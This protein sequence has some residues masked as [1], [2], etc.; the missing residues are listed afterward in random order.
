MS[1]EEQAHLNVATSPRPQFPRRPSA[2]LM[3]SDLSTGGTE[4]QY[5]LMAKALRRGLFDLHT[6]C[7]RRRGA[8]LKEIEPIAEFDVGGSFLTYQAHCARRAL[9]KHLRKHEIAVAHSFDFYANLMLI[10]VARWTRVPVVI[11]SQRQLGDLLSPMQKFT[12][13]AAFHLCTRVVC[14]SRAAACRLVKDG[15][16]ESKIVVIPNGLPEE[17]FSEV[18]TALTHNSAVVRVGLIA[19]MNHSGKN[20]G[21]LLQAAA[22]I[23][24]EFPNAEYVLVGDGPLRK[25]LEQLAAELGIKHQVQ[26]LGERMDIP[27]VMASLDISVV[28][29]NSESLSNAILESMA[30]GKP[31]MQLA[32][33]VTLN[34]FTMA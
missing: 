4:R 7:M 2:F 29:S 31:V 23:A 13:L 20:Q 19:R 3:N 25:S 9:A 33:G 18:E 22:Q 34:S 6:G 8:F 11:G 21:L 17:A 32:W 26:F 10:P 12:Q 1:T 15:L 16:P 5:Y 30:A 28:T 14:N 24:G 27:K